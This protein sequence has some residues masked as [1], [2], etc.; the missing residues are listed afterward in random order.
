MRRQRQRAILEL[1]ERQAVHNQAELV[2]L[3]EHAGFAATQATVSRDIHQLGLVKVPITGGGA[4][5]AQPRAV[6]PPAAADRALRQHA[7]FITAVDKV[8]TLLVIRTRSGHAHAVAN[9]IDECALPEIAGTLAGDD[10][11][12][13]MVRHDKDRPLLLRRFRE[14]AD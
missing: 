6:P 10:T 13:V 2:V 9:A 5:Y 7:A 12:L 11:I 4:R 8:S 1:F 14:L 3:L